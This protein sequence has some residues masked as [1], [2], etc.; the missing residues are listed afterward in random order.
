M[1][2]LYLIKIGGQ[3]LD[4]ETQRDTFLS[5]FSRLTGKKL[6]VHGG[7]KL[8]TR[9]SERLGIETRMTEGRRITDADTLQVVTMVYAGWI[10]KTIVARLQAAG[11]Q[12][13]GFSGAD[14]DL[15]RSH[16]RSEASVDYGY[17]GDVDRVNADLLIRLLDQ[18]IT[19][20]LSPI[21]HDGQGQLL[22]TNADTIAQET[23]RALSTSY[24]VH[25]I[26]SFEKNGVL[27][28]VDDPSSRIPLLTP[29]LYRQLRSANRIF[30]GMVPKL[31]NAFA[32]LESG[33]HRVSIGPAD[34]LD[35][36]IAGSTGTT[37]QHEP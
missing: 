26:Y 13:A 1:D 29:S 11:C 35:L 23:A 20:V 8:A 25:L 6:L 7:G 32:A 2:E 36:L 16:R 14:G 27:E 34:Q 4:D 19:P 21:T 18:G 22:N 37:L 15:V 24:R 30:A 28:R 33:I 17:V 5:A 3:V 31:D 12:A 9:L 10:N